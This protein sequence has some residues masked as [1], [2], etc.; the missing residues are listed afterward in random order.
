MVNIFLLELNERIDNAKLPVIKL[1]DI[2]I[3]KK[4]KRMESVFSK[5]FLDEI[6][7]RIKKKESVIILQNRRGFA[8][9]VYCNDCG[10]VI[11]CDDCSV[12]MVHHINKNILQC[13]YCGTSKHIPKACPNC[14]SLSLKFFGTGTQRVEDELD[15]YFPNSKIERI[16]SDSINKKGKLGEILNS[17]RKGEIDILVGTQMVSKGLDFSNVTLVGVISAEHSLWIPD[18]R[19]DERT[20]QLLTQVSGRAGRSEKIGEVV[21]Q[22]QNSKNFVRAKVIE[23]DYKGF[24]EREIFTARAGRIPSVFKNR[25]DRN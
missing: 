17:F 13:H 21:I 1:V 2:T 11:T 22:T 14:G 8:T 15:Y 3:E 24:Y 23:N 4:K 7:A 20:F 6:D 10:E 16:D 9:Q 12:A 18:F 25:F 5:T 19:A